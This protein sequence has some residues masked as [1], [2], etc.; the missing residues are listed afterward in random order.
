LSHGLPYAIATLTHYV[1][2]F[3][4]FVVAVTAA[5]VELSKF[6]IL[7]G[8]VGVG[9]GFGLQNVVAD[10]VSGLI[11]LFERPVRVGDFLEVGGITGQVRKIGAR[12]STLNAPDGSN[13][14]IPN[15]KLIAERVVN[16]TLTNKRRQIVLSIPVAYGTDPVAT[17]DLI[18]QAVEANQDVLSF[19]RPLVFF[20]GFGDSALNFEVRFWASQPQAVGELRSNVALSIASALSSAGIQ[21]P[22]PQRLLRITTPDQDGGLN[23]A[24]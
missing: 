9:L 1:V 21:I 20:T 3:F 17:R 4:V 18:R 6:T 16:W 7:T 11:L 12:S 23:K 2:L 8:A 19:P 5:G 13:L 10:F 14:I 24:A 22:V 15:S